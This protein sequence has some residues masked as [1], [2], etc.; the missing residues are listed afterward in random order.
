MSINFI[1]I[2]DLEWN[3]PSVMNRLFLFILHQEHSQMNFYKKILQYFKDK[4]IEYNNLHWWN[5]M[6]WDD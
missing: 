3:I 2:P 5:F 1:Y 4:G 6:A